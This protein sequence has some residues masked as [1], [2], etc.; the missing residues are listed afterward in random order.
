[1]ALTISKKTRYLKEGFRAIT[2]KIEV[3]ATRVPTLTCSR[4]FFRGCSY[5]REHRPT[6]ATRVRT[7]ALPGAGLDVDTGLLGVWP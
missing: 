6:G 7:A 5:Q 4:I 3:D 1:M 2:P